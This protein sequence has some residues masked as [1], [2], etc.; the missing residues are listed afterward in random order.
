MKIRA[1][2]DLH[3]YYRREDM[4]RYNNEE[5]SE[6][7]KELFNNPPDLLVFCGDLCHTTYKSDDIRFI[8]IIKFITQIVDICKRKNVQF[9][10]LQGTSSHDGKIVSI[11]KNIFKN[12]SHVKAFTEVE[13]ENFNGTIIRYLPE[14]YFDTYQNFYDYAFTQMADITFFHGSIDKVL[15]QL[16]QKDN[17]TNLPKAIVMKQEDLLANTRLFS[18][19]GHI[20]KHFDIE[21][22]TYAN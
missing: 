9:R 7:K 12:E 10:I 5:L 17:V 3:L 14:P 18:A 15:P 13:Y 16:T 1:Y 22:I 20:H 6:L 8:N 11:I 4:D 2:A 19:G 21:F